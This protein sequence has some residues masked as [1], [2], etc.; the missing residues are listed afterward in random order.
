[1]ALIERGKVQNGNIVL[2]HPLALP[3]DTEVVVH[4]ELLAQEVAPSEAVK[5]FA[6]LP[7][8]GMWA[9]RE[10]MEDSVAW[11]RQERERWQQR[12]VRQD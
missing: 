12:A 2:S 6:S 8:F 3:E 11:V 7:F 4:I 9:D 1:M 10:D 5:D